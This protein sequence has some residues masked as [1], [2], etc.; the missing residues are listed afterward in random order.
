M[1]SCVSQTSPRPLLAPPPP[2]PPRRVAPHLRNEVK[3]FLVMDEE[4]ADAT[5]DDEDIPFEEG[6]LAVMLTPQQLIILLQISKEC[7]CYSG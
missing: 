1:Q 6:E 4:P 7:V 5:V 3:G 2:P